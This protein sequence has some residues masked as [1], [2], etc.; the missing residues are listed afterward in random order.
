MINHLTEETSLLPNPLWRHGG[1]HVAG[2]GL[3]THTLWTKG[4]VARQNETAGVQSRV[5]AGYARKILVK[6]HLVGSDRGH[7]QKQSKRN[8]RSYSTS[9]S[10][11]ATFGRPPTAVRIVVVGLPDGNLYS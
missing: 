6:K 3:I 5:N 9:G 7:K 4:H 10:Q 11:Y 8:E 1:R 2:Q